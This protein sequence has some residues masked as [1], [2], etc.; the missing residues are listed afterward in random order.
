[1]GGCYPLRLFGRTIDSL[2][3]YLSYHSPGPDGRCAGCLDKLSA[4]DPYLQNWFWTSVIPKFPNAHVSWGFRDEEMQNS[5]LAAGTTKLE[6]PNSAHNKSPARA[7]D[8]FQIIPG[9]D[10]SSP[11]AIWA[12]AFF[13]SLSD[14]IAKEDLP[15]LW[16]GQWKELGDKDHFELKS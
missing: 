7:I 3:D 9:N 8:L 10:T 11:V 1:M 16:G 13:V 4:V 12:P 6:W 2:G 14:M 5:C 15:I